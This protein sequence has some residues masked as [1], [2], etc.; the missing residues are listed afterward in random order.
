MQDSLDT[1]R[2]ALAALETQVDQVAH[3]PPLR[4]IAERAAPMENAQLHT[5]LAYTLDSLYFGARAS[6][7]HAIRAFVS[8]SNARNHAR[9]GSHGWT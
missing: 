8:I 6:V 1:L 7:Y 9:I 4:E 5:A 2:A 3:L